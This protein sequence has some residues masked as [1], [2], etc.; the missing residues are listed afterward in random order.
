VKLKNRVRILVAGEGESTRRVVSVLKRQSIRYLVEE[1]SNEEELFAE[2]LRCKPQI[3][4]WGFAEPSPVGLNLMRKVRHYWPEARIVVLSLDAEEKLVRGALGIGVSSCVLKS[5]PESKIALAVQAALQ[6]LSLFDRQIADS[7]VKG[8]LENSA[9]KVET[10]TNFS[11]LTPRE[12][13]VVRLLTVGN[14]NRQVA[15]KLGIRIRTVETHRANV[16]RKLGVHTLT[17]L[18]H[19]AVREGIIHIPSS[20][21][22]VA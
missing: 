17:Q 22:D 5:A 16:M 8:Y 9:A 14:G 15:A 11:R 7:V 20:H 2:I 6:G 3:L 21:A 10:P 18:I 19:L 1:A 12:L 4:V 13:E